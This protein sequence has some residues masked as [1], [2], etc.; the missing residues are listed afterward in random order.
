MLL[1]CLVLLS[2]CNEGF[3]IPNQ[4]SY[5]SLEVSWPVWMEGNIT[6]ATL[7]MSN[8][9]EELARIACEADETNITVQKK[10]ELPEGSY[11][12]SLILLTSEEEEK[13]YAAGTIT[14]T[15]RPEDNTILHLLG[16]TYITS[17]PSSVSFTEESPWELSIITYPSKATIYYTTDGSTP[18]TESTQYTGPI[19]ITDTSTIKAKAGLEGYL[20]SNVACGTYTKQTG[21]SITLP[22]SS[23]EVKIVTN[24]YATFAAVLADEEGKEE[25]TYSW[26]LFKAGQ[27]T[28]LKTSS[29]PI[30][31]F[32][33]L[34]P[35]V[36]YRLVVQ[37]MKGNRRSIDSLTFTIPIQAGVDE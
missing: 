3:R 10:L 22:T 37:T 17:M 20:I 14:T 21:F 1:S 33:E 12:L 36:R 27:A 23:P 19:P 8:Q 9:E 18:T 32:S 26:T 34:Q 2:S 24:D 15:I 4:S 13:F 30:P 28:P 5:L 7:I 31:M 25:T 29:E 11:N 6:S 16:Q 35:S